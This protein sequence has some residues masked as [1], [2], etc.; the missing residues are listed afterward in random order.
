MSRWAGENKTSN[1]DDYLCCS[2]RVAVLVWS[3]PGI[4][5]NDVVVNGILSPVLL[6]ELVRDIFYGHPARLFSHITKDIVVVFSLLPVQRTVLAVAGYTSREFLVNVDVL[7]AGLVRGV[8]Y[9]ECENKHGDCTT[10]DPRHALQAEH[11][12]GAVA[13]GLAL[14]KM[15]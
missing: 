5:K 14:L 13:K 11:F 8:L 12:V 1:D 10:L 4:D 9:V 6:Q 15:R 2:P 7:D 3:T